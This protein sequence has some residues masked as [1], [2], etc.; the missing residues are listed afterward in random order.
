MSTVFTPGYIQV[1]ER[2][3]TGWFQTKPK[4]V[5]NLSDRP[6]DSLNKEKYYG[7]TKT[8]IITELFKRYQGKL[9]YYLVNLSDRSYY[10]CGLTVKDLQAKLFELEI[11]YRG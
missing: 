10:Y 1:I 9:G 4:S 2:T 7:L 3:Q 11:N 6:F 5:F 8:Q